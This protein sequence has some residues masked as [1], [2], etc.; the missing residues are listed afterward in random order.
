MGAVAFIILLFGFFFGI[1]KYVDGKLT[2]M[3]QDVMTA[4]NGAA[5]LLARNRRLADHKLHAQRPS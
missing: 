4:V 5:S 3:R 1:W 2:A